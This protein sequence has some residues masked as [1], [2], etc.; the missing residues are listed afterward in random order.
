MRL[1]VTRKA[2]L[3]V[4]AMVALAEAGTRLK[5]SSLAESLQ[6]TPGFISQVVNPLVKA[7]WVT[8]D[9]GPAGGYRLTV[10][11]A[12]VS[13]LQIV[14][15]IDG[16]TD[17]GRCVVADRACDASAPCALHHAWSMAR[18]ELTELLG[19]VPVASLVNPSPDQLADRPAATPA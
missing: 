2:D 12:D 1:E 10:D 3:A 19:G 14:E 16:P 6:S 7:G 5:S 11:V 13:V 4:R 17:D 8:S 15:L 18:S 9:P